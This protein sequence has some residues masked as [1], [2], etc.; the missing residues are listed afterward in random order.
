MRH[1][2]ARRKSRIAATAGAMLAAAAI[3]AP[4][5]AAGGPSHGDHGPGGGGS[6]NGRLGLLIADH[7]EPPVYN[8]ATYESF[9]EFIDHLMEMGVIPP[10]LRTV[11]GGTILQDR[12]CYGCDEPSSAPALIDAWLT[13]HSGPGAWV[14]SPSE[15]IASHYL[16]PAGPG[17]GEPDIFEHAGLQVWH[18]WELM[19]GRSPNYAQKLRKKR[20]A[21][22]R[23]RQHYGDRLPIAVGYGIDPRIRGGHQDLHTAVHELLDERVKRIAVVYHGV[24]FSDLM[25]THMIRHEI[26]HSLAAHGIELPI[27]Y[28]KPL[29][30]TRA[31]RRAVIAKALRELDRLPA[32]APVAIHLSGHGL[33]TSECGDYDCGAD[34]YHRYSRRLFERT[35]RELRAAIERPGKTGVF[36]LYA[37]GATDD[38]DPEDLVDSPIEALENR[39]AAGY[40]HVVDIPYEF[41]SD[42]RDTLIVLRQGYERPIPDW[43]DRYESRFRFEGMKVKITNASFGRRL[44]GEALHRTAMGAIRAAG[45]IR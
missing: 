41:D 28:G 45:G 20:H 30:S 17:Q 12:D 33:P 36:H 43:N 24:G 14:A 26:E 40:R 18:E 7:G 34:A 9:R 11:D 23:L 21:I 8:S 1:H 6:A 15:D 10:W 27:A 5:A 22:R 25:Q 32:K 19:G 31:Y 3:A 16:M 4:L 42:S 37:D 35:S 13:P 29:G 38:D 39:A 44:K 2:G